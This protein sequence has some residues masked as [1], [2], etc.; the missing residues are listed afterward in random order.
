MTKTNVVAPDLAHPNGNG[1]FFP[2]TVGQIESR[3]VE[4]TLQG[5]VAPGWDALAAY[6]HDHAYVRSGTSTYTQGSDMPFVPKDMLRLFSTLRVPQ[7]ALSNVK[8]GAGLSW[9]GP[10]AGLYVDPT[11]FATDTSTIRSPSYVVFDAMAACDFMLGP[12]R[13]SLQINVKNVFNRSYYTDAFMYV[14]PRGYVTYGAPRSINATL[15]VDF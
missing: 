1:G 6:T 10:A 7:Q 9:Q 5:E 12:R 15:K 13:A 11:T 4:L 14:A 8:V 2:T 3:G